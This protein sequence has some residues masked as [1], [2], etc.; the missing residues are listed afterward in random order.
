MSCGIIG[1]VGGFFAGAVNGLLVPYPPLANVA[2]AMHFD[3][4]NGSTEFLDVKDNFVFSSGAGPVISTT[5]SKFGGASLYKPD[6]AN[7]LYVPANA[8]NLG[9]GD[10]SISV[11]REAGLTPYSYVSKRNPSSVGAGAWALA[12]N[13]T[14]G[15][16]TWQDNVAGGVNIDSSTLSTSGMHFYVVERKSG[17]L[18]IYFDGKFVGGS[19][20]Y[21][22]DLTNTF[23]F[24]LQ[25]V[26]TSG[27]NSTGYLDD[28]LI[29]VG[30]A[31]YTTAA[32]LTSLPTVG[33][34]VFNPPTVPFSYADAGGSTWN[35]ADAGTGK[36]TFSG[37]KHRVKNLTG[38]WT[39]LRG[40]QSRSSGKYYFEVTVEA[41]GDHNISFGIATSS[42]ALTA[43][44][45]GEATSWGLLQNNFKGNANTFTAFSACPY[46][47][48]KTVGVSVD[49]T[50]G[51]I[52]FSGGTNNVAQQLAYSN[53]SG[54]VFPAA[55]AYTTGAVFR[56]RTK[57]DDF[58]YSIPAG[59]S[60]WG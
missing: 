49:F 45:G 15:K 54:T 13:D 10:F 47:A 46:V 29:C 53:V 14:T 17:K 48:G 55:S 42:C 31:P 28:L 40:T 58:V 2:L 18:Y 57:T 39:A 30:L 19:A 32:G 24:R 27:T 3:G 4:A 43:I 12:I 9:A 37:Y 60:E 26:L 23:D 11:W 1:A 20:S 34:Q 59:Y 7:Y 5:K 36:Y 8:F 50:T 33:T 52:Y 21:T 16:F 38:G 25:D 35:P 44:V 41:I 51:N 56:L 22:R 6:S